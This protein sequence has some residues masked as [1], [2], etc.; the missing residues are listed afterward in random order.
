VYVT[1]AGIADGTFNRFV[2]TIGVKPSTDNQPNSLMK[3]TPSQDT[4]YQTESDYVFFGV[5]ILPGLPAIAVTEDPLGS[6]LDNRASVT[7][8]AVPFAVVDGERLLARL[9]LKH[10]VN[11]GVDPS[12]A[13]GNRF[14]IFVD[15]AL[16]FHPDGSSV[17]PSSDPGLITSVPEPTTL[18]LAFFGA[19]MAIGL[20]WHQRKKQNVS[21][22]P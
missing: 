16:F 17:I 2:A 15:S 22:R 21:A 6:G 4:S 11:A 18:G 14:E 1:G 19:A 3:F 13:W 5:S 9:N 7:D 8:I 20:S 12:R 10:E